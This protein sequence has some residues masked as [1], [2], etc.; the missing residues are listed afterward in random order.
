MSNRFLVEQFDLWREAGEGLV[1]ATVIETDGSTYSKAGRH[2]LINRQ[3]QYAGLVGGGC[4]EGDLVLQAEEVLQ[5][6][7]P[8]TVSYDMRNDSDDLWGMGLG[9]RGMMRLLLQRLDAAGSWQPLQQLTDWMRG[10]Q[11][12]VVSLVTAGNDP[13]LPVGSL[14][15]ESTE[16]GPIAAT[17]NE[18]ETE[19]L[20][21]SIK[22]WPRLLILGAG[23]DTHPVVALARLLGWHVTVADHRP[24]LINAQGLEQADERVEIDRSNLENALQWPSY[25]AACVM[26][27]HL[28]TDIKYLQV[29]SGLNLAYTGVL[30]PAARKEE[31]LRSLNLQ[32]S[33]F[34]NRLH[35]P[36]GLEIHADT[37]QGI[38]LS[39]LAEI[40]SALKA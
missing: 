5:S 1:L 16:P 32:G 8:R 25:T 18:G 36:V 9:C 3:K 29:L 17:A 2:L 35:G 39:L 37:P 14:Q 33:E 10:T 4:L 27:H 11:P 38:A 23:P 20:I 26:S 19:K 6:G 31:I 15:Q 30:G 34:A 24:E 28:E 7:Q 21:W 12:V 13:Q 40:H 22:P